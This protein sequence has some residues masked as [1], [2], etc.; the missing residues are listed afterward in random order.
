MKNLCRGVACIVF[1]LSGT[2][3]YAQTPPPAA[4]Q[5]DTFAIMDNSFFVEEAFNQEAG[6][7][8]NIVGAARI[9][10]QWVLAF[11]QEWPVVSQTHQFSYTVPWLDGGAGYGVGD[12]LLNYRFQST[13]DAPGI[14]AFSPRLSIILPTGSTTRGRGTAPRG[15]RSTSHS[16]SSSETCSGIGMAASPGCRGHARSRVPAPLAIGANS[17]YRRFSRRAVFTG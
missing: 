11:T 13:L 16:A 2:D 5:T 12:V 9:S 1:A 3:A 7:F 15:C 14:P 8:Q 4:P 6:I 17:S 10:G